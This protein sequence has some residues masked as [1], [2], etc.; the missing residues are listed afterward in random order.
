MANERF[1]ANTGF[2]DESMNEPMKQML[3]SDHVWATINSLTTPIVV[4][5]SSELTYKNSVN[6]KLINYTIEFE[7]AYDTINNIR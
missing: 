7:Y 5:T 6:D 4:I 3:L 2:M 1:N